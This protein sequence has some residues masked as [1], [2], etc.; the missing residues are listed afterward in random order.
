M[1]LDLGDRSVQVSYVPLPEFVGQ[2]G[3][4]P[5]EF[6]A[7]RVL[8]P[9][10]KARPGLFHA[11]VEHPPLREPGSVRIHTR[12]EITGSHSLPVNFEM[13]SAWTFR[14]YVN[15]QIRFSNTNTDYFT[16]LS[17]YMQLEPGI[18]DVEFILD[19]VPEPGG[20]AINYSYWE[21]DG[22][23][24]RELFGLQTERVGFLP[25]AG[26]RQDGVRP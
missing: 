10:G 12:M 23:R 21:P 7:R 17:N 4:A 3:A 1:R 13:Y 15:G 20:F 26:A 22:W 24:V 2:S 9:H 11:A 19:Y 18:Y 14:M 8:F 6:A 25:P 5:I 16:E